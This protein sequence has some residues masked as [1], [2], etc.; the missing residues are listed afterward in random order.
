MWVI[1]KKCCIFLVFFLQKKKM[2]RCVILI[3]NLRETAHFKNKYYVV[4]ASSD[5]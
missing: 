5:P 2:F 3:Y 4:Q 1:L